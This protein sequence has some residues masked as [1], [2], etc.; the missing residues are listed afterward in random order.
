ME[1]PKNKL[2][3]T[4]QTKEMLDFVFTL[5]KS[6]DKAMQDGKLDYNDIITIIPAF[7]KIGLALKGVEEIPKELG[8]LDKKE[9][10]DLKKYVRDNFDISN[11]K[12][13][14]FIIIAFDVIFALLPL[15]Q[16]IRLDSIDKCNP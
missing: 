2:Y 4:I 12:V 6:I 15:L 1:E 16:G 5:T 11:D 13:E 8:D 9:M 3:G 14:K 10:E 7:M